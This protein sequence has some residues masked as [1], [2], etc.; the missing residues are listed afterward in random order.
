MVDEKKF[1]KLEALSEDLNEQTDGLNETIKSLEKRLQEMKI[2]IEVWHGATF[3]DD[4]PFDYSD[5]YGEIGREA[6]TGWYLGFSKCND[7][8]RICCRQDIF[9]Y[10]EL[11]VWER[12]LSVGSVSPL[13]NGPRSVRLFMAPYLEHLV[14]DLIDKVAEL[15]KEV[16]KANATANS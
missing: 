1:K 11:G 5:N 14:D 16:T 2:G 4:G 15:T 8:W 10:G 3:D 9:V 7:A 12:D 6:R 13:I